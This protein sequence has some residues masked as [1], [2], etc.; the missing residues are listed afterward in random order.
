MLSLFRRILVLYVLSALS[1]FLFTISPAL[2]RASV[3]ER[4]KEGGKGGRERGRYV[5]MEGRREE[6]RERAIEIEREA[7]E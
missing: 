1:I 6:K 3:L 4:E 5:R 7:I 2:S